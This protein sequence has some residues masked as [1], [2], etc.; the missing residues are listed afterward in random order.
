M[1]REGSPQ[2]RRK[3]H[4]EEKRSTEA[5]NE[6]YPRKTR[7]KQKHLTWDPS[8]KEQKPRAKVILRSRSR[9]NVKHT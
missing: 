7:G 1:P 8:R 3:P 6:A 2:S 4:R 9:G 5:N